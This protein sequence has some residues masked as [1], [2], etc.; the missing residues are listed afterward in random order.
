MRIRAARLVDEE[1]WSH[2]PATLKPADLATIYRKKPVT[3]WR[4]LN[5]ASIPGHRVGKSW[6]IFREEVRSKLEDSAARPSE[7]SEG[8]RVLPDSFGVGAAAD[9]LGVHEQTVYGW[10]QSG[11]MPARQT[12]GYWLIFKSELRD[13]LR[14]T[15][16]QLNHPEPGPT[17]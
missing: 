17:S 11:V 8:L 6:V 9:F 13:W 5:R 3:I 4:W 16:N 7:P 15:S 12:G 2:F 14:S 10:L 1:F